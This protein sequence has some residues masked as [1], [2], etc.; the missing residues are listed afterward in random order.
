MP[1]T[2]RSCKGI[3]PKGLLGVGLRIRAGP[4]NS[5]KFQVKS[6]Q[7]TKVLQAKRL[8]L[9]VFLPFYFVHAL[10]VVCLCVYVTAKTVRLIHDSSTFSA[11][12]QSC[13][14]NQY[15]YKHG[16]DLLIVG[17]F[18]PVEGMIVFFYFFLPLF[19]FLRS[20]PSVPFIRLKIVYLNLV[21]F[22]N[23]HAST[24]LLMHLN[25]LC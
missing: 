19:L 21:I 8:F 22:P 6:H 23:Y 12:L 1:E 10:F 13:S 5:Y 2:C 25:H 4:I 11:K 18:M 16:C 7:K 17:D 15:F 9:S 14:P 24:H 20:L 3:F